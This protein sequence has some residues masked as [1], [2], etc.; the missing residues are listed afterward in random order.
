MAFSIG[1]I[2]FYG[3]SIGI[4]AFS[5]GMMAFSTGIIGTRCCLIYSLN[6]SSSTVTVIQLPAGS[7]RH[8]ACLVDVLHVV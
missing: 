4:K 1:I 2:A 5:T 6:S 3:L 8:R 7:P